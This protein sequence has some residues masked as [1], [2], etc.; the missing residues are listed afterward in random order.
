LKQQKT[1]KTE[2]RLSGRGLFGGKD[3]RVLFKPAPPDAGIVFVRKDM[4]PPVQIR[5]KPENIVERNRRTAIGSGQV[6]VETSE[7]CLAAVAAL[8]IDN[9]FI[10]MDAEELPGFDGSSEEFFNTLR[11]SGLQLQDA[12][13]N[14]I[15]VTES[16]CITE[17]DKSIYALPS[18]GSGLNI[19]YDLDY[20]QHTGI[21]RQ[22]YSCELNEAHYAQN[23][24]RARTFVLEAE[25]LQMQ[26]MGVG[27]HLGPKD[28][29][30]INS[31]GP[32]KN[33]F[34]F[35]DECVRHK[36]V[37][38]IGDLRLAGRPII[39]RVVAY[40]SGHTLNQKLVTRIVASQRKAEQGKVLSGKPILDIKRIQR[41]LPHRY[42]FLLVDKVVEI[43]KDRRIKGI[44]NVTF[45]EQFFQ[46]HFPGTPVMPG[47][48]IVEA[49]AQV[50][51]L[52]FAQKLE[53]TGKLAVLLT[54]DGVKIRKS[55]IPG[56]QLILIAEADKIRSRAA[57]CNCKAMV[58][59][60]IVAE[61]QL[62]FMLV[63]DE[64]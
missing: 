5:V 63:D 8:D 54:M 49:L 40:K 9:L 27:S 19:T 21:G 17:R 47:V 60:D 30:V 41:I 22:I 61:A 57:K 25:A 50:S 10:E 55:V 52:L 39:G 16:I 45:N 28:I 6:Y 24:A 53:H 29:L 56:D 3:V 7:H 31:D 46:G 35:P 23:L 36:V 12:E 43:E 4:D 37:D 59:N 11:K 32:I 44:K 48:L 64:I 42:P 62:K 13:Q 14:P 34:R 58:G 38:L 20:T 1:I 2:V 18:N 15:V 33:S 26:A 51:G